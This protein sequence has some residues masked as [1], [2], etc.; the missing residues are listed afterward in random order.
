M[1]K[2]SYTKPAR[3]A[4]AVM[5]YFLIVIAVTMIWYSLTKEFLLKLD[6]IPEQQRQGYDNPF[7]SLLAVTFGFLLVAFIVYEIII[8]LLSTLSSSMVLK[9]LAGILAGIFP[10]VCIQLMTFGISLSD[11]GMLTEFLAMGIGGGLIP[12]VKK[13]MF[14]FLK[15]KTS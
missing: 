6:S 8:T 13:L 14:S 5:A 1:L 4:S 15:A 3:F 10:V 12:V 9:V 7:L 2:K 11:P